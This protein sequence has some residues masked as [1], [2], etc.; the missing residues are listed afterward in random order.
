MAHEA[1]IVHRDIKAENVMVRQTGW[2]RCWTRFGEADRGADRA[3]EADQERILLRLS[4]EPGVVMGCQLYVAG[5]LR[6]EG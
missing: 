5:A 6:I 3:T 1:G 2:S 4:T